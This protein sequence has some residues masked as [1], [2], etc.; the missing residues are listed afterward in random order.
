MERKSERECERD[1]ETA[2]GETE[3]VRKM[4]LCD[5]YA[6]AQVT[7]HVMSDRRGGRRRRRRRK[8]WRRRR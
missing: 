1:R 6:K 8:V 3:S 2:T 5:H 7:R 4:S